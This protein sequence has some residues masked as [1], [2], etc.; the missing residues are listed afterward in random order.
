MKGYGYKLT[1]L[2]KCD[3]CDTVGDASLYTTLTYFKKDENAF[4][5]DSKPISWRGTADICAE[6]MA[7]SGM[8]FKETKYT[9]KFK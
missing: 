4:D 5:A 9:P 3:K 6:D 8:K 2:K 7:K 1:N